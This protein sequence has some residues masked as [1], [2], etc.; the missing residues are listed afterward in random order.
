MGQSD[1]FLANNGETEPVGDTQ[2][3]EHIE[4]WGGHLRPCTTQNSKGE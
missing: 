1:S 3:D 4:S 2:K